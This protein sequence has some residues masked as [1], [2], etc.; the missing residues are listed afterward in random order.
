MSPSP[1][2]EP[3]F[4]AETWSK[5]GNEIGLVLAIALVIALAFPNSK[6]YQRKPI[7]SA[8]PILTKTA[9]LGIF[10][11]GAGIVII[12]G[13]IDL[14]AGSVIAL[15]GTLFSAVI[16]KLSPRKVLESGALSQPLMGEVAVWVV[17]LAVV[18]ALLAALLVGT[19][20][21][22]L[23]TVIRLPPFVATLASLVGLRSFARLFI[24]QIT[25]GN[26]VITLSN[27]ALGSV[28]DDRWWLPVVLWVVIA[29]VAWVMLSRS[30]VGRHLYAMGGNEQAAKLSGIRTDMLKWLAYCISAVT[31]A[32]SGILYTCYIGTA[33]PDSDGIGFE[34]NAIA[35]AVVG[36]CSLAGGIG[37]VGGIV[38]GA[39]FLR[40]V[41]DVVEKTIG[42]P[43]LM[44]GLV[45]GVMVVLAV[46]FNELRSSGG[47]RKQYFPGILGACSVV[48]LSGLAGMVSFV[49]LALQDEIS[50]P[51]IKGCIV[52]GVTFA[53]L[54]TKFLLERRQRQ[55]EL[56]G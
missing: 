49:T 15:S 28:G 40:V 24:Q 1:E 38:L 41:I 13:G 12:S 53:L 32:I 37:T 54:L 5:C 30:I 4:L 7:E 21:T 46:A 6:A 35:S 45:V 34:L 26:S 36:G 17:V 51:G 56:R 27:K 19:F 52:G 31:A 39:L 16:W 18:V 47:F 9:M 14:S 50:S 20:H 25:D 11:I 3:G 42:R 10:A 29:I 33:A 55:R 48:V 23:I 22:W 44:E 8:Q 2:K 43:D